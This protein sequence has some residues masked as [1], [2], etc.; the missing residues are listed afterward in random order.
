MLL[1]KPGR[2]VQVLGV[3][4]LVVSLYAL[5]VEQSLSDP[6]YEPMCNTSWGSCKHLDF[7][8]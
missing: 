8:S 1:S 7:Y 5:H 2:R 3:L 6:F 4:G